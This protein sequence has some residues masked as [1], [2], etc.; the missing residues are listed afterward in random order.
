MLKSKYFYI[1][2]LVSILFGFLPTLL[3]FATLGFYPHIP[4][5]I[6][7]DML[8]YFARVREVLAG[9]MFIGNPYFLE[10]VHDVTTAFFVGD[11]IYASVFFIAQFFHVELTGGII[12]SQVVCTA[13]TSV[14]LFIF[15]K[16]IEIPEKYIPWVVTCTLLSVLFFILRPVSMAIVY[17]CFLLFL[18]NF[19]AWLRNPKG[20]KESVF[21]V[22]S[23]VLSF[24]VYTYLWQIVLIALSVTFV[25]VLVTHQNRLRF[26]V[27]AG[28]I[29]LLSIPVFI[30]TWMQLHAPYY[31]ETLSRVGLVNT[32][33]IGSKAIL[34]SLLCLISLLSIFII[35]RKLHHK[36]E[37][38][39]TFPSILY[40]ISP[41]NLFFSII[42][43]SLL[44]AGVSNV[45][46]GKDL[47]V[48]VH[49]GRFTELFTTMFLMYITWVYAVHRNVLGKKFVVLIAIFFIYISTLVFSTYATVSHTSTLVSQE[50]YAPVIRALLESNSKPS[51]VFADDT[52][53]SYI[54]AQ[55][56][57]YV[58]FHPNGLLYLASNVEIEE[59]YLVSRMFSNLTEDQIKTDM[60]KYAGVGLTVHEANVENRNTRICMVFR[61]VILSSHCRQMMTG[62]SI[63]GEQ[64][65]ANLFLRYQ[66][67]LSHKEKFLDM[68]HVQF[69]VIDLNHNWMPAALTSFKQIRSNDRFIIL[70]RK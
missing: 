20:K 9:H 41:E 3:L 32:H 60:R 35:E 52:L 45:I 46:S 27:L 24:Y 1:T 5:E 62:E 53:S 36:N 54:V 38:G 70:E 18:I 26:I 56:N 25:Y 16:K 13:V 42:F 23:S 29:G 10:H 6:M 63:A 34:Y 59:R 57:D 61:R 31:F 30:Y 11:W 64:Y 69:I 17:P 51:V 55:T 48:A 67:I 58:V 33:S 2:V 50:S 4:V 21:L 65:F 39:K 14:L 68:Y 37:I 15:Y 47:E 12:A 8:Y 7:D 49:V 43:I 66:Y 40:S 28:L 44:I 22:I 19:L